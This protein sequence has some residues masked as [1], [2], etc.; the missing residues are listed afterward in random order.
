DLILSTIRQQLF[1]HRGAGR[2]NVVAFLVYSITVGF[3]PTLLGGNGDVPE[4]E[5]QL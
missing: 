3:S 1:Q 2:Q 4:G 5:L